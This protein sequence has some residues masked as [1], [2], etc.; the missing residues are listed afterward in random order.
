MRPSDPDEKG[1]SPR[2]GAKRGVVQSV[3]RAFQILEVLRN[4]PGPMRVH[5]IAIEAGLDRTVTHRLVRSLQREGAVVEEERAHYR[6]GP[7]V[8]LLANRYIDDLQVRRLA[9]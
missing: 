7:S 4:A 1:D 3:G 6:L 9:M 5:D 2:A 8:V